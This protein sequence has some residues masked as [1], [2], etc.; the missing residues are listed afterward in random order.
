VNPTLITA[1][2]RQ[3]ATSPVR[4]ALLAMIA[5]MPM[6]VIAFAPGAGLSVLGNA[7]GVMLVLG[8]GMIGQDVSNGVLQLLFARPVTRPA[9]V[10]NR[11]LA[12]AGAGLAVSLLQILLA[13]AIL[14]ARGQAPPAQQVALFAAGRLFECAGLA[15]VL[16]LLSS[17]VGGIA[18]LGLYLLA[19]F[20]FGI[21]QMAGQAKNWP[22]MQSL[23]AELLASLTPAID[24]ERLV[25]TSPMPWFPIVAWL[26]T[27][28]L[29]L[30]IAI[31][32]V[33]RRELSYAS[34]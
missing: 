29:C 12:V 3:R 18:D 5:G 33:N 6:L 30:A 11:W 14:A 27:V 9:Y 15:A 1:L 25:N 32:A 10:V 26:S 20:V 19:S 21:V 24:L 31:M 34:G 4:M 7:Q 8:A 2:W 23:G 13:S 28:T 17:L 22:W 16:A